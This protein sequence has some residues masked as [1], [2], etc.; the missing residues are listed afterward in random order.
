MP[1]TCGHSWLEHNRRAVTNQVYFDYPL[2]IKGMIATECEHNP[3]KETY[4]FVGDE[5]KCCSCTGFKPRWG[6]I[7]KLVDKWRKLHG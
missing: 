7:Q 4:F 2:T 5:A 6:N 1:C 3:V